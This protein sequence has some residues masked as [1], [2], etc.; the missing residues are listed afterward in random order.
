MTKDYI[1][2]YLNVQKNMQVRVFGCS[3]YNSP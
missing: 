2:E 1:L 3:P